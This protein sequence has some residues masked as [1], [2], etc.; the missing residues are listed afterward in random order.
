MSGQDSA[1]TNGA[2]PEKPAEG[3]RDASGAEL[4]YGIA[5]QRFANALGRKTAREGGVDIMGLKISIE[6]TA[7]F[8][9]EIT[10]HLASLGLVNRD[11]IF[12]RVAARFD[13]SAAVLE[14]PSLVIASQGGK[15]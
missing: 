6:L 15:R 13:L 9:D 1:A 10:E 3:E 12:D 7:G 2:A 11:E 4:R 14:K 5:A 8:L